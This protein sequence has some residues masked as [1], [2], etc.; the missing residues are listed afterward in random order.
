VLSRRLLG[1]A[2]V[3]SLVKVP[4][5]REAIHNAFEIGTSLLYDIAIA[6]ITYGLVVVVAAWLA[7]N[8]RPAQAVRRAL[9]PSLREHVGYVYGT[10]AVA[11]LLVVIWGPFPSTRQLL[12]VIGFAVLIALGIHNLQS[13]AAVEFPEAQVGDTSRALREWFSSRRR[14]PPAAAG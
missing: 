11:L 4:A 7:G 13:T 5:N 14:H 2:L 6:L 12:P 8:T 1:D 10:G 3:N 9:A